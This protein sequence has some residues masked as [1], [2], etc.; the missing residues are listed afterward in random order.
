MRFAILAIALP[1]AACAANLEAEAREGL[2][3]ELKDAESA[4]FRDV[5]RYAA[6][7]CGQVNSKNSFGAY[8]G[9][10]QFYVGS[11]LAVVDGNGENLAS[12]LCGIEEAIDEP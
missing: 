3:T 8:A 4:Q 6:G 5:E 11:K 12:E 10:S 7:I 1:L 2:A 9:F